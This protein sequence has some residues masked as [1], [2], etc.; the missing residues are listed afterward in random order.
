MNTVESET[1]DRN[2]LAAASTNNSRILH[3]QGVFGGR[4]APQHNPNNNTD[5]N[6]TTTGKESNNEKIDWESNDDD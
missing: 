1:I 5:K 4:C 6:S 2:S 3:T